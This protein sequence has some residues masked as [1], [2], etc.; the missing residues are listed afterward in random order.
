MTPSAP[1]E[2]DARTSRLMRL[3]HAS[4]LLLTPIIAICYWL[5]AWASMTLHE[6]A[7]PG[8]EPLWPAAAVA[9]VACLH[10]GH[11]ALPGVLVGALCAKLSASGL[12]SPAVLA[13]A[14][15]LTAAPWLASR[16]ILRYCRTHTPLFT[17]H[18]IS[19]FL[20]FGVL[21]H[22]AV[23]STGELARA[24]LLPEPL[25]AITA[26][27]EVAGAHAGGTLLFAPLLM[28]AFAPRTDVAYGRWSA[29]SLTGALLTMVLTAVIFLSPGNWPHELMTLPML[30]VVPVA[31]MA[32]TRPPG[33]AL[34]FAISIALIATA[35][36]AMGA[37][38]FSSTDHHWPYLPQAV[39]NSLL[40]L[41]ALLLNSISVSRWRDLDALRQAAS[42][43]DHA[44]EGILMTDLQ[45]RIVKANPAF[46]RISG[47]R[48]DEIV[49]KR[50]S[51]LRSNRHDDAFYHDLWQ[52]LTTR[53][54]WSG[55]IWNRRKS[56]E[57][58]VAYQN[59]SALRDAS[60]TLTGYVSIMTDVTE[61]H[62]K[63]AKIRHLA[64]NDPLT[65]LPNRVLA[66]ERL[67]HAL[68]IAGRRGWRTAVMMFNLD[69]FK[70]VNDLLGYAAGDDYICEVARQLRTSVRASDTVARMG[71]DEFLVIVEAIEDN[72]QIAQIAGTLLDRIRDVAKTHHSLAGGATAGIATAPD[73]SEEADALIADAET[74]M[75]SVKES[76]GSGFCFY[77][78]E[79]THSARSQL[80]LEQ[81]LRMAIA[82]SALSL[83]YQP[84]FELADGRLSGVEALARWCHEGRNIPPDIF[85]AAA[86][87]SQQIIALGDWV[88]EE[89]IGQMAAWRAQGLGVVPMAI[90]VSTEQL[91]APGFIERLRNT[92]G[93][94]DIPLAAIE[95]EITESTMMNNPQS[96]AQHTAAL[97][98]H[99]V[100]VAI[101]D[102]GTG[103]SSL[104][105]LSRLHIDV[106]KIDKAFVRNLNHGL[107]NIEI[108]RAIAALGT[109][110]RLTIVAEGIETSEEACLL[111]HLGCQVGQGY[112][113]SRPQ[114]AHTLTTLLK[115]GRVTIPDPKHDCR[116]RCAQR[117][118]ATQPER[119]TSPEPCRQYGSSELALTP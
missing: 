94:Y 100:R 20:I 32:T 118:E 8:L 68:A 23:A 29:D 27:I 7:G 107:E 34:P 4:A 72:H 2:R 43:F 115:E 90:N 116:S 37:G 102:F 113:M 67:A 80:R 18:D 77:R 39:M 50:P 104:A 105:Y 61:L 76:G 89:A 70:Q 48:T 3:D 96:A 22:A 49:G 82:R 92:A 31:W 53:M 95:I 87:N 73:D 114:P 117:P 21:V 101:D 16:L 71:S 88:I 74:A 112:L 26:W 9:L 56:G 81:D 60:G 46:V 69:R 19:V 85:I 35:G 84:K 52:A 99:G 51:M 63:E 42:I 28:L 98:R 41:T 97:Q 38:P 44:L 66:R 14:L 40:M 83:H 110:L 58:F 86:E 24:L 11:R 1:G 103:Y 108:V 111:R 57:L 109:A 6:L 106:I 59:I 12:M 36:T 119:N 91:L 78:K 5:L 30:L 47:Y 93:R 79:M 64:L 45:G 10:L 15:A 13:D 54:Q 62:A 17:L 33:V 25:T 65:A 75:R 55:E